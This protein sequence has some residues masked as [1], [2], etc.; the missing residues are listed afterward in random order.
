MGTGGIFLEVQRRWS[1]ANNSSPF[2]AEVRKA[3]SYICTPPTRLMALTNI[4]LPLF[5]LYVLSLQVYLFI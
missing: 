5:A 1:D 3:W 2:N 4:M